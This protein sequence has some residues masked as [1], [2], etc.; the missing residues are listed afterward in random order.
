[1]QPYDPTTVVAVS[2]TILGLALAVSLRPAIST[3]R[4]DLARILREE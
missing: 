1:V 3:A 2:A 4:L